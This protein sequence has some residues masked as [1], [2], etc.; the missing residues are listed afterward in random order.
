MEYQENVTVMEHSEM[1]TESS[2]NYSKQLIFY[3]Y[4]T[5]YS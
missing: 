5:G 4:K 1:S 2:L 3:H